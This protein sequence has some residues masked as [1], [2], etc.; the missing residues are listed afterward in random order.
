[1][2]VI[3]LNEQYKELYFLCLE[4]WSEEMREADNHKKIWYNKMKDRG[5]RVKLALDDNE[6]VGGMIQYIPILRAAENDVKDKGAKGMVAWGMEWGVSDALF[7]D[8]KQ[9]R[10]GPPPSY[11]KIRKAISKKVKKL[12]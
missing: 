1:M 10:T 7:I 3:D 2:K 8:N 4:D 11:E 5:L 12:L 6:N 9:V